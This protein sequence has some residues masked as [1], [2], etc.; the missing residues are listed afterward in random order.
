MTALTRR[1]L[2]ASIATMAAFALFALAR[3]PLSVFPATDEPRDVDVL[4][5]LGPI[6]DNKLATAEALMAAGYSDTL[7]LSTPEDEV[8]EFCAARHDFELLCFMPDPST[9]QG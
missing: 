6:S 4:F 5:V 2:T 9:T 8:A 7:V 3:L 1:L